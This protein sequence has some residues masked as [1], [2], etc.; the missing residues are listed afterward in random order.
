MISRRLQ[1]DHV[2]FTAE[3]HTERACVACVHT[4]NQSHAMTSQVYIRHSFLGCR[5]CI[6][7]TTVPSSK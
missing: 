2:T 1:G 6:A 3:G 5:L 7:G 4:T